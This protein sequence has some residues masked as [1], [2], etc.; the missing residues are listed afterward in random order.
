MSQKEAKEGLSECSISRKTRHCPVLQLQFCGKTTVFT[1]LEREWKL[2]EMKS[3]LAITAVSRNWRFSPLGSVEQHREEISSTALT[4]SEWKY[5]S[6]QRPPP[7]FIPLHLDTA[8]HPPAY[9]FITAQSTTTFCCL[10]HF[11]H[12][13]L[14]ISVLRHI[15]L[16]THITPLL[17]S[18]EFRP[19]CIMLQ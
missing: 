15:F 13:E 19:T 5:C 16:S 2:E 17:Y 11:F 1:I 14:N 3:P 9:S 7:W 4:T 10:H 8:I 18:T 6:F 12:C